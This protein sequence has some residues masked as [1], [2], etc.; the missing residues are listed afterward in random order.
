MGISHVA[1]LA[2]VASIRKYLSLRIVAAA[3][4][5]PV[6]ST[7]SDGQ[8]GST[9]HHSSID[10]LMSKTLPLVHQVAHKNHQ[11]EAIDLGP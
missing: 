5:T 6:D 2:H 3:S 10:R 9:A 4:T 7:V 11:R 8:R 1:Q